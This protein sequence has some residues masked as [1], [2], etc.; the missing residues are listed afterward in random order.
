MTRK[1]SKEELGVLRETDVSRLHRHFHSLLDRSY[2]EAQ[3]RRIMEG[4][5]RSPQMTRLGEG[6]H[7]IAY[8]VRAGEGSLVLRTPKD[9][10]WEPEDPETKRWMHA[11]NVLGKARLPLIPPFELLVHDEGVGLLS[12]YGE[13]DLGKLPAH[14]LPLSAVIESAEIELQNLGL[15]VNDEYQLAHWQKIPFLMDLSDLHFV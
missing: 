3:F 1:W 13:R 14:W 7:F 8:R 9:S 2:F 4:R 12:P 15:K 10:R 11:M 5:P 6:L